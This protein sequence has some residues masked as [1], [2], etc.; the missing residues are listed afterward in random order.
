M[1]TNFNTSDIYLGIPKLSLIQNIL[2]V[3]NIQSPKYKYSVLN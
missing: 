3:N 2:L 1:K